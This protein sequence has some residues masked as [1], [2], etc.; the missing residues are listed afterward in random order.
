MTMRRTAAS[1]SLTERRFGNSLKK[2]FPRIIKKKIS[3]EED[4]DHD[5]KEWEGPLETRQPWKRRVLPR[6]LFVRHLVWK[7]VMGTSVRDA[8]C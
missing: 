4:H 6:L 7:S 5:V 3:S 2:H 1:C 8:S